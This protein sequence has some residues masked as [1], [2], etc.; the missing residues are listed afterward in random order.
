MEIIKKKIDELIP[1]ENN[2]KK[3]DELQ[4]K[5]VAES[6]KQFGFVQPIVI[7]KDDVIVIGH[8][9]FEASKLLGMKEVPCVMV[10]ELTEDQVK[11]LRL[12]DNKT[13]E[14]PWD[15]PKLTQELEELFGKIDMNEFG[16]PVQ[17]ENLDN[18]ELLGEEK[19]SAELNEANNY[20]VLKFNTKDD[21]EEAILK[22]GLE[23]VSTGENSKGIRRIGIGRVI[24]GNEV[25]RR[26]KND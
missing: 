19:I 11:G 1:Y 2:A 18:S 21:W 12:A 13:N 7:D 8:C 15:T 17:I 22:L 16:F 14:S 6:I 25:I 20:V 5:N 9:R 23:R 26:I 4:I 3:H 10:D 24:E